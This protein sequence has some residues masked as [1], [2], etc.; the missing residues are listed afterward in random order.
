VTHTSKLPD[1]QRYVPSLDG[2][3]ACSVLLVILAHFGLDG[4]VPGGFGVTAFFWISGYL[5]TAQML[6]EIKA[7]GRLNF[8]RFYL[9]RALRL[10]PAAL[11]YVLIAAGAFMMI[12]GVMTGWAWLWAVLYGANY[13]DL[14]VMFKPLPSGVASPLTHLWSLAVEEHFY[15]LWPVALLLLYRAGWAL[16]LLIAVCVAVLL[17]RIWLY[18]SCL[19]GVTEAI[20]GLRPEYRL[21]KATDTRIDSIAWGAMVAVIAAGRGRSWLSRLVASPTAQ[22]AA[23]AL[24][25]F[26]FVYRAEPFREVWRYS[27]Q[28]IALC[29]LIPAVTGMPSLVRRVLE[30]RLIVYVGRLSYSIYLWHWAGVTFATWAEPS[31]G[32][33]WVGVATAIT[34]LGAMLSYYLIERPMVALRR[35]A[36][37][38][39]FVGPAR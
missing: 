29:V 13:Y 18:Q 26:G 39:A 37:S 7:T 11:A 32:V 9:R 27:L 10:M 36:G 19:S 1:T 8:R 24:L 21:Y 15:I 5:L 2:L 3:R 14:F 20:C 34:V 22:A 17:W 25:L 23:M 28:G 38:H 30:W 33:A 12:G 35:R 16:R 6:V 4:F 31:H